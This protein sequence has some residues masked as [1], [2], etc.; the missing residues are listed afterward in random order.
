MTEPNKSESIKNAEKIIERFGGIRPMA[1]KIGVPVT[2][3]Q[4]WKKRDAIPENRL[5][6]ILS[7]ANQNGID[8]SDLIT[9]AS[10]PDSSFSSI[11]SQEPEELSIEAVESGAKDEG[12]LEEDSQAGDSPET[13]EGESQQK[14]LF[15]LEDH[16]LPEDFPS[17]DEVESKEEKAVRPVDP[18]AR[19]KLHQQAVRPSA[20]SPQVRR[21]P[22][23]E[24]HAIQTSS[25]I[26]IILILLVAMGSASYL[27]PKLREHSERI[28]GVENNVRTLEGTVETVKKEQEEVKTMVPLNWEEQ[29]A[30]LQKQTAEATEMVKSSIKDV[31]KIPGEIME[32]N[33]MGI[34]ERVK[35]FDNY[36]NEMTAKSPFAQG[37]IDS[38]NEVLDEEQGRENISNATQA[39]MSAFSTGTEGV[40]KDGA[41]AIE[42]ARQSDPSAASI[43]KDVPKEDLKKAGAMFS[44]VQIRDALSRDGQPFSDQLALLGNMVGGESPEL[45]TSLNSIAE[46][47]KQGVTTPPTLAKEFEGLEDEVLDTSLKEDDSSL[48]E[49][50]QAQLNALLQVEKDGELLT[51]TDTQSKLNRAK[52]LMAKGDLK[53]AKAVV[54]TLSEKEREP[55]QDW[56]KKTEATIRVQD[57]ENSLGISLPSLLG[58]ENFKNWWI[59]TKDRQKLR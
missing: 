58:V 41:E 52:K 24:K 4:G 27:W 2:T 36:V 25:L 14:S 50:A 11:A 57:F 55:L 47:A 23:S 21:V 38:L 33:V 30:S 40:Q 20:A 13:E 49:Q 6:D 5:Q 12:A 42:E 53:G 43:F 46:D 44:L 59:M 37:F 35:E 19:E 7:A 16:E 32:G 10:V 26:S 9:G 15:S 39:L 48:A 34:P 1:S 31:Q 22:E 18:F 29:L 56:I 8:L 54:E 3:V 17:K 45:Q 51:G 28:S